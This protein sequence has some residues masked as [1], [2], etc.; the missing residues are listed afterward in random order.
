MSWRIDGTLYFAAYQLSLLI[1]FKY[2]CK[3]EEITDEWNPEAALRNEKEALDAW[4][5]KIKERN[6]GRQS[7]SPKYNLSQEY[8]DSY[9]PNFVKTQIYRLLPMRSD[10]R[11]V[12]SRQYVSVATSAFFEIIFLRAL[13]RIYH[14][15]RTHSTACHNPQYVITPYRITT[16]VPP[17]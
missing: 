14:V 4:K 5:V 11:P 10:P 17:Y 12:D 6:M 13:S 9:D 3:N 2:R 15:A 8:L 1:R 7:I 16:C